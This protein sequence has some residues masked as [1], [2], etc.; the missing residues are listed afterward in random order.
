MGVRAGFRLTMEPQ[1]RATA[2]ELKEHF[3]ELAAALHHLRATGELP[4]GPFP[5]CSAKTAA[6]PASAHENF[7]FS[8]PNTWALTDTMAVAPKDDTEIRRF[9]SDVDLEEGSQTSSS[10]VPHSKTVRN[11][12]LCV[13]G[14]ILTEDGAP[15]QGDSSLTRGGKRHITTISHR[16]GLAA[17][18]D[19]PSAASAV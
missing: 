14:I 17:R 13:L 9:P 5:W 6:V 12:V 11:V 1:V 15:R 19:R 2:S 7:R 10:E 4:P 16:T 18:F 8:L 3:V